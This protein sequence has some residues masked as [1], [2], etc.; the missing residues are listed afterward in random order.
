MHTMTTSIRFALS[1]LAGFALLGATALA[2]PAFADEAPAGHEYGNSRSIDTVESTLGVSSTVA[3]TALALPADSVEMGQR[4]GGSAESEVG[5][6][7][8]HNN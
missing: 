3:D 8:E 5:R 7:F 1:A 6:S 4:S 2:T